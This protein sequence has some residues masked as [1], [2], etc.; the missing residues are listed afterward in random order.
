MAEVSVRKLIK[1]SISYDLAKAIIEKVFMS[2]AYS[3][4]V[5]LIIFHIVNKKFFQN[6]HVGQI[7][8]HVNNDRRDYSA[9]QE[10]CEA[11]KFVRF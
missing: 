6:D 3:I 9:A 11:M 4:A 1:K 10:F 8:N 5:R 2:Y 7:L